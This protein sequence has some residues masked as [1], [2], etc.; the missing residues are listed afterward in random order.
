MKSE[1]KTAGRRAR[2]VRFVLI[3]LVALLFTFAVWK[4]GSMAKMM[5]A[6]AASDEQDFARSAVG[7]QRS[8]CWRLRRPAQKER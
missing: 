4:S 1:A 8:L 2:T 3:A 7:V 5:S 6:A